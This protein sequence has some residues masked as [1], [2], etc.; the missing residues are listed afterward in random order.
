MSNDL[1]NEY[2]DY[3][4]IYPLEDTKPIAS[5]KP[6]R[7]LMSEEIRIGIDFGT[8]TTAI[9][10][11]QGDG[12]S[13]AIPIGKDGVTRYMPSVVYI[14]PGSGE[15]QQRA[16]IGEDADNQGDELRKIRSIKRCFDCQNRKCGSTK[17]GEIQLS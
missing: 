12:S 5:P 6:V 17:E 4:K 15:L 13:V 3:E 11:K 8:S 10:F 1:V 9:S 14:S 2:S 7:L 16:L